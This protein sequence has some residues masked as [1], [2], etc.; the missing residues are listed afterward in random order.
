MSNCKWILL[1]TTKISPKH[2]TTKYIPINFQ[3]CTLRSPAADLCSSL[4]EFTR[5]WKN[6]RALCHSSTSP[7]IQTLELKT[8]TQMRHVKSRP[9]RSLLMKQKHVKNAFFCPSVGMLSDWKNLNS[10]KMLNLVMIWFCGLM[11]MI[12]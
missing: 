12:K 11:E 1:W 9:P 5:A 6:S 4:K 2:A 10:I 7:S 8:H 3:G